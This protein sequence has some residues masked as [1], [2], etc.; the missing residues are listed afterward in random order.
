MLQDP[1]L[2][3]SVNSIR[4]A[5]LNGLVYFPNSALTFDGNP[6]PSGPRCLLLVVN[7]VQVDA[8]SRFDSQ[9]CAQAGL[10]NLPTVLTVALAE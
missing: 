5:T 7:A 6:G 8:N 3:L 2:A 9:G 4:G 10:V 1:S